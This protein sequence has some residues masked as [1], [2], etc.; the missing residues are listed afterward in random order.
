[1]VVLNNRIYLLLEFNFKDGRSINDIGNS[2]SSFYFTTGRTFIAVHFTE[3]L[4]VN[5]QKKLNKGYMY[6][7]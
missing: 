1:M 6:P 4:S 7:I 3:I 5:I 2:I